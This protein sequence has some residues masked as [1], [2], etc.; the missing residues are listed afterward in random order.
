MRG[1]GHEVRWAD[2]FILHT[3]YQDP[4]LRGR[5]LERDLRLLHLEDAERPDDPFT[6]FNLGQ[7]YQELGRH[8]E[9]LPR[10]R[11]SLEKSAPSDS[12][13]RKLFALI[14]QCYRQLGQKA[15]ALAACRSGRR[16]YP[17]DAELL[18]LFLSLPVPCDAFGGA[19]CGPDCLLARRVT[20]IHS[21]SPKRRAASSWNSR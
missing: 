11:R 21:T 8:Q 7:I 4:A 10:L 12:I 9:A 16:Y 20:D 13:V 6:L 3:G 14:T 19:L 15:E 1:H 18:F 17:E 5:K 2:V